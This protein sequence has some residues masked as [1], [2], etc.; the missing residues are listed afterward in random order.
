SSDGEQVVSCSTDQTVRVWDAATGMVVFTCNEEAPALCAAISTDGLRIASGS[1]DWTVKLWEPPQVATRTLYERKGNINKVAFSPDG[2]RV[3]AV[4][5][6]FAIVW[7]VPTGK[8]LLL[9]R[10]PGAFG[11]VAW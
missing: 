9:G 8:S 5:R 2:G 1:E 10:N 3:A 7:D 6:P 4:C 11:R